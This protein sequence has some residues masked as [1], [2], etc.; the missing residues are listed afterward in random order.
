[1]IDILIANAGVATGL[2][3]GQ[4]LETPDA[5][6]ATFAINVM[7][8]FNTVE[9]AL[10]AMTGRGSGTI[11]M[12]GSLAGVRGLPHSPA[13]CASKAAVHLYAESLRGV[14]ARHGVVVSL[15]VPGYVKTPMS[16]RTIVK[17]PMSDGSKSWQPGLMSD[18]EAAEIVV[19]GLARR[20]PVIAFPR[21]QYYVLRLATLLPPRLVDY[22]M[23]LFG[24]IVPETSEREAI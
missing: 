24:A 11:A 19:S 6:R 13:Y 17:A 3:P 5:V 20:K 15:I 8:V 18:V 1:P 16:E 22:V 12:V 7:G 21:Y 10:L 9:P 14:A 2:S 23:N 4:I